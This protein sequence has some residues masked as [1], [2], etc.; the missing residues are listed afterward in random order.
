RIA[1]VGKNAKGYIYGGGSGKVDPFHY[2]DFLSGLTAEAKKHGAEVEYVDRLDFMPAII[3]TDETKSRQGFNASYYKN[4]DLTGA[5]HHT[6]AE[7]HISYSWTGGTGIDGMPNEKYSVRWKAS[8]CPDMTGD[9]TFTLGGDDGYR[10]KLD[11]ATLLDDWN[12]GAF[13]TKSVTRHL[14]AGKSYPIEIEYFQKGGGAGVKFEWAMEGS[15]SNEMIKK[16]NAADV[17]IACIGHDADT[18]AEGSDRTFELPASDSQLMKELAGCRTPIIA[19]VNG[20]GNVEMQQWEP[21]VKGLLWAWYAGQEGGTALADVVFG[22]VNPSGKLPMTFEK[23]WADNPAYNSYHDTDGDR[24]VAYDEG[25]FIGYR[26]Y[27]R[28][29]TAVQYPFGHG[30]SYTTFRLSDIKASAQQPDGS[31]N[32]SCRLTNTGRR[33]GSQVIQ[34]YTGKPESAVERPARELK[35][36]KKVALA[37][38][39]ST[40]V[41]MN[42]PREAFSYYS[43]EIHDFTI[44]GGDHTISL[45]FSSRDIKATVP[46]SVK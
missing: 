26:G 27:D 28:N 10:L 3:F 5:P 43:P 21:N 25:I 34:A 12:E 18:E 1:V 35:Q 44:E 38:G 33:A 13:R 20:G 46:V 16:L 4:M 19:V 40:T 9:Y 11:G 22:N 31:F 36:F 8:V 37:P 6:A 30:L 2:V 23:Q 42:L 45:G 14:E 24:H 32:V 39:E 15:K 41:T 17:V 7:K 29:N